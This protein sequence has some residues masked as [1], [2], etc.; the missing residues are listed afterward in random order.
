MPNRIVLSSLSAA[1]VLTGLCAVQTLHQDSAVVVHA[2]EAPAAPKLWANGSAKAA[3]EFATFFTTKYMPERIKK[4]TADRMV[5]RDFPGVPGISITTTAN[6]KDGPVRTFYYLESV[7]KKGQFLARK[8]DFYPGGG[9]VLDA[10]PQ[11]L[12]FARLKPDEASL[13]GLFA[14]FSDTRNDADGNKQL[15]GFAAWLYENG[16]PWAGNRTLTNLLTRVPALQDEIHRELRAKH[17]W[18]EGT[19]LVTHKSVGFSGWGETVPEEAKE[20]RTKAREA[21]CA[22]ELALA[23]ARAKLSIQWADRV[24]WE[25]MTSGKPVMKDA[26]GLSLGHLEREIKVAMEFAKDSAAYLAD[27]KTWEDGKGAKKPLPAV[28]ATASY[29]KA[30]V[31]ERIEKA[32]PVAELASSKYGEADAMRKKYATDKKDGKGGDQME[33]AFGLYDEAEAEFRKLLPTKTSPSG[34]S[35]DPFNMSHWA[36][37]AETLRYSC[38]PHERDPDKCDKESKVKELVAATELVT[39]AHPKNSKAIM[40][41][42][43]GYMMLRDYT[44]SRKELESVAN[45]ESQTAANRK[46][47]KDYIENVLDKVE[48]KALEEAKIRNMGK[49]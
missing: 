2:E 35:L 37:F 11:T 26:L 31:A 15:A 21:Q 42:A 45:D 25:V 41:R 6:S 19:A 30:E 23:A 36:Q 24:T 12:N 39:R 34:P 8:G 33:K 43:Q 49:R 16:A 46:A 44:K 13:E 14:Y 4:W 18:A 5:V 29:W 28:V 48:K 9:F 7:D 47:A 20:E 40:C 17:K 10:Q 22:T 1:I 27:V 38:R 3:E 32:K